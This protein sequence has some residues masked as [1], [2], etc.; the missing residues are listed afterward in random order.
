MTPRVWV[1]RPI[2]TVE[3]AEALPEGAVILAEATEYTYAWRKTGDDFV[4]HEGHVWW[5]E[6]LAGD[7]VTALVPVE[8]EEEVLAEYA[9][10]AH[11][12]WGQLV[13]RYVTA[14][15]DA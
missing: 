12:R 9:V 8:A 7:D 14:W 13:R 11:W 3:D 1:E 15:E 4:D 2:A 6:D 5:P 10:R